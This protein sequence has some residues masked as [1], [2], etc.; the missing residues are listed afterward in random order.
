M[1]A[2]LVTISTRML[3]REMRLGASP[4]QDTLNTLPESNLWNLYCE[5][6]SRGESDVDQL[7]VNGLKR[8]HGR[9]S[10]SGSDLPSID[11]D[12]NEHKNVDDPFLGELFKAYKRCICSQRVQPAGQLLRDIESQL[13]GH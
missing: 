6:R 1:Q 8:L 12:P 2:G 11:P 7:L 3:K 9:R 10:Y 5:L 13:Q 4:T